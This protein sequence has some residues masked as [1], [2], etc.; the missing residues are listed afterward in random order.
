MAEKKKTPL[1]EAISKLNVATGN[2]L[3]DTVMRDA[4]FL[5]QSFLPKEKEFAKDMFDAAREYSGPYPDNLKY[6]SFDE[7]YKQYEP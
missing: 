6:H 7:Y 5:L 4:V 3:R 2:D 1:Q